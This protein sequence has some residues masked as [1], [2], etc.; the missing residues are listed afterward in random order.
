MKE[1]PEQ[2]ELRIYLLVRDDCPGYDEYDSCVVA[3]LSEEDARTI[4][5]NGWET[6]GEGCGGTWVPPRCIEVIQVGVAV[7]GVKRGVICASF[8]AG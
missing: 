4:H 8:N 7:P 6:V 1:R 5:P 2:D 3:A